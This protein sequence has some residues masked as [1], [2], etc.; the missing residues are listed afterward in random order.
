LDKLTGPH[1]V[2]EFRDRSDDVRIRLLEP[3]EVENA[4]ICIDEPEEL[5]EEIARSAA[6]LKARLKDGWRAYAAFEGEKPVAEAIVASPE[7]SPYRVEGE[8]IYLVHC[9]FVKP[10][11]AG[12]G[13]GSA[14]MRRIEEELYGE[15]RGVAVLSFGE[16]WMPFSFFRRLGY[17]YVGRDSLVS[18]ALKR[19]D[20][21]ARATLYPSHPAFPLLE[22][23][24]RVEVN[25]D[26]VCP[27]LAH[28]YRKLADI[29]R[30]YGELTAV[31]ERFIDDREKY[32]RFGGPRIYF[33]NRGLPPGPVPEAE[34]RRRLEEALTSLRPA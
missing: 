2:I 13:V 12:R 5:S 23:K 31:G 29:A 26:P 3:H 19:F 24:L 22:G 7:G 28:H 32:V 33:D 21:K 9:I 15:A 20:P 1:L 11:H 14:L 6:Y 18:L 30:S 27:F 16:E 4:Y 17:E 34:F 10:E 25:H 8:G